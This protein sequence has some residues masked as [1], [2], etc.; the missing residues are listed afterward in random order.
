MH[1]H[2]PKTDPKRREIME[3]DVNQREGASYTNSAT[4]RKIGPIFSSTS[5]RRFLKRSGGASAATALAWHGFKTNAFAAASP[6]CN[7]H[8]DSCTWIQSV[9]VTFTSTSVPAALQPGQQNANGNRTVSGRVFHGEL[10][11]T[12]YT[13]DGTDNHDLYED[14]GNGTTNTLPGVPV[15]TGGYRD[16]PTVVNQGDDTA[17]PAGTYDMTPGQTGGTPG[18]DCP[19][20]GTGRTEME[21]H[22]PGL[23]SGCIVFDNQADWTAFRDL[24][25][26][27]HDCGDGTCPAGMC[28]HGQPPTPQITV[29][30]VGVTPVG[31]RTP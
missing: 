25:N 10:V 3:K 11:V 31:N 19:C 20:T 26:D 17:F 16:P 24:F 14:N 7:P 15:H 12:T 29:S 30:Y 5:R 28:V 23:S 1:Y 2:R 9:T 13:C 6:H 18:F 22:G 27:G 21:V 4:E 8:G